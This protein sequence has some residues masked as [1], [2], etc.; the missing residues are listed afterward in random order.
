MPRILQ[1][2]MQQN[3]IVLIGT[4]W[5]QEWFLTGRSL[6]QVCH[7]VWLIRVLLVVKKKLI[8]QAACD[9]YITWWWK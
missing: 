7:I 6:A 3:W 2:G 4:E 9:E 1:R 8:S 5:K